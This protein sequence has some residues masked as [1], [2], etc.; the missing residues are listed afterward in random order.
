MVPGCT[1][2]AVQGEGESLSGAGVEFLCL[3]Y[4]ESDQFS[5]SES[6]DRGNVRGTPLFFC[7]QTQEYNKNATK[8][9]KNTKNLSKNSRSKRDF[10]Q[11][12]VEMRGIEPLTS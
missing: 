4:D 6:S 12:V 10:G 3:Q 2:F 5:G 7:S 8:M 9:Q 1:L 11:I